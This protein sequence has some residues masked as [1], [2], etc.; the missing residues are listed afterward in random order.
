MQILV[1]HDPRWLLP[2]SHTQTHTQ[3]NNTYY[4]VSDWYTNRLQ[5]IQ[6]V[7]KDTLSTFYATKYK[8][9]NG[10]KVQK[11]TFPRTGLRVK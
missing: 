2:R 8:S 10:L 3:T 4:Y 1:K 9:L 6:N 5:R 11:V 7:R